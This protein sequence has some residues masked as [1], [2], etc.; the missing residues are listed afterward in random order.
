M[1]YKVEYEDVNDMADQIEDER[2]KS[3]RYFT[4]DNS[5]DTGYMISL[6]YEAERLNESLPAFERMVESFKVGT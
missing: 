3:I 1:A 4:I 6:Q 2:I 5:T